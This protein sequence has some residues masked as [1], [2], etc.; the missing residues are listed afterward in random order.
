MVVTQLDSTL[1]S[2]GY[3][4]FYHLQPNGIWIEGIGGIFSLTN[5]LIS[6]AYCTL[7]SADY[8]LACFVDAGGTAI[9]SNNINFCNFV[10]LNE[11]SKNEMK[12]YP[13]P[14]IDRITIQGDIDLSSLV[15]LNTLGETVLQQTCSPP[16][17]QT[18]INIAT[19]PKGFYF[20]K[21]ITDRGLVVRKFIK[22]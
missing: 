15:I 7:L 17:E 14:V 16:K 19:L 20:V 3:H 6:Q 2:D 4:K 9:Y 1:C 13:N 10:G 12:I 21:C 11:V 22:E 8:N 18:E 5:P